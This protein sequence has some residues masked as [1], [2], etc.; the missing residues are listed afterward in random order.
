MG[1]GREV[2][3]RCIAEFYTDANGLQTEYVCDFSPWTYGD[4]RKHLGVGWH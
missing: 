1:A 3:M 2:E 4:I